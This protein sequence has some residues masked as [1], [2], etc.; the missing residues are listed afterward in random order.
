MGVGQ[1]WTREDKT[2][3][4]ENYGL[5]SIKT[6]AKNLNRSADSVINKKVRMGLGR[7]LEN[8]EY[9]T[10]SQLLMALY[11]QERPSNSY[12]NM[13]TW[14]EFPLRKKRVLN[15]SFKVVYLNEFWEWAESH[16]RCIDFS[17][18]EENILGAEPDWAKRKRK[19][20]YECRMK[21]TPWSKGEDRELERLLLQHKYNYTDLSARF[22]RTE[23][24]IRRRIYNLAI[25]IRPVRAK[26][27]PWTDEEKVVLLFMYEEGWSL[28]KIGAKLG[29]TANSCRGKMDL[30]N[31]PEMYL[32][33]NR[34][35]AL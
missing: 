33:K 22:N 15:N 13:K 12:R 18:M 25:D 9:V 4:E 30:L 8:G 1:S 28:E 32:R 6:I 14:D 26:T 19:I 16:R 34:R 21:V 10:L 31:N 23:S 29:R 11:G 24:A 20:D 3:L 17:K 7:F 27:K 35:E 2:Y 5:I